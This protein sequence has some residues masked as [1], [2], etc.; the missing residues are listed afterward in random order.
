MAWRC[1]LPGLTI[2]IRLTTR[3]L[4]WA[5]LGYNHRGA[6]LSPRPLGQ[7]QPSLGQFRNHS[8]RGRVTEPSP[9]ALSL[10]LG[11]GLGAKGAVGT[12]VPRPEFDSPK[13]AGVLE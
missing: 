6:A 5:G 12:D 2:R 1:S 4:G 10:T 7:T 13:A 8:R 9:P 11:E 3:R